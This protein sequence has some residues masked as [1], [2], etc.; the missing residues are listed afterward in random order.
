MLIFVMFEMSSYHSHASLFPALLPDFPAELFGRV[1]P[2]TPQRPR[3][4]PEQSPP[5][6]HT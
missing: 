5:S 3:V 1:S 2:L 4:Q 6:E